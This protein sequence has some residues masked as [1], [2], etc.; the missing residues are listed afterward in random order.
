MLVTFSFV[1][2]LFIFFCSL[3]RVSCQVF[4]F[5][6]LAFYFFFIPFFFHFFFFILFLS[7]LL[8]VSRARKKNGF[9]ARSSSHL[10]RVWLWQS[11]ESISH[12]ST[13]FLAFFLCFYLTF[14]RGA[15]GGSSIRTKNKTKQYPD[16]DHSN[17]IIDQVILG[18]LWAMYVKVFKTKRNET[19]RDYIPVSSV[20]RI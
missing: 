8:C 9:E 1:R 16:S 7:F 3:I 5:L 13:Q 17:N 2:I 14:F 18:N 6:F 20:D 11:K 15:G 19:K 4:N 10:D 12:F